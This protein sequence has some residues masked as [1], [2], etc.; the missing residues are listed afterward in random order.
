MNL[1][2]TD[3]NS[4]LG[5]VAIVLSGQRL[6]AL[7]FA[8]KWQHLAHSLR[9]RFG[10]ITIE[11]TT[12]KPPAA[13]RI[14]AYFNGD[15]TAL[16]AIPVDTGGTPFQQRIWNQLRRIPLGKTVSYRDIAKRIGQPTATRAVGAA[17]AAN[18]ISLVIP[19]HR[20]IRTDGTLCGY[21]GGIE[22]KEWLLRHEG[23]EV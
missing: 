23:V 3:I 12:T 17:N 2:R 6:C 22:R 18:P 4:P 1:T 5:P 9:R 16:D 21:G 7:G 15:L 20:V 11:R 8:D 10:E 19:C 14:E 13:E